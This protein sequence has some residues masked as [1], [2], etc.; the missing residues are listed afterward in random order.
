VQDNHFL[1]KWSGQSF[2]RADSFSSGCTLFSAE[3]MAQI[4]EWSRFSNQG[5][6]FP[7]ADSFSP[8]C[9]LFSAR[10]MAQIGE[11]SRLRNQ[12]SYSS[13]L[14]KNSL[15]SSSLMFYLLRVDALPDLTNVSGRMAQMIQF[16]S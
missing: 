3:G 4:G 7:R 11:W 10:G 13:L 6:A 12:D 5:Q 9:T 1:R 16:I 2:L 8:G 14:E 15:D